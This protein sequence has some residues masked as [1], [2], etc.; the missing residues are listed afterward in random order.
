MKRNEMPY[1]N[2]MK[3][4][5]MKWHMKWKKMKWKEGQM[6]CT[7]ICRLDPELL[8][9]GPMTCSDLVSRLFYLLDML[10]IGWVKGKTLRGVCSYWNDLTLV[11]FK[12]RT[13][14]CLTSTTLWWTCL[15]CLGLTCCMTLTSRGV[16]STTLLWTITTML[17]LPLWDVDWHV[18]CVYC[19]LHYCLLLV[20]WLFDWVD[21]CV[22]PAVHQ[23]HLHKFIFMSI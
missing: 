20:L 6:K 12:G 19:V 18:D 16:L 23:W 13:T 3:R 17:W 8:L 9:N 2:E 21:V 1:E 14:L 11:D 7:C 5:E 22:Y 15:L 10:L 4:D